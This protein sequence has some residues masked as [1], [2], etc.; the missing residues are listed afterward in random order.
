M[1]GS[2][3]RTL[4]VTAGAIQTFVPV[5][6]GKDGWDKA[7]AAADVLRAI[8]HGASARTPPGCCRT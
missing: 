3:G 8:A 2:L 4:L 1:R 6:L 7:A 5:D